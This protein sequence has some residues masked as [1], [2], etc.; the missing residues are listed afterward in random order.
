MDRG[1]RPSK[2]LS[3]R[4][5]SADRA[6]CRA[7]AL[8]RKVA[9]RREA[10]RVAELTPDGLAGDRRVHVRSGSGPLTGRTRS[11]LLTLPATTGIDGVP[12]VAGAPLGLAGRARAGARPGRRR[13]LARST[14]RPG[15][16]QRDATCSWPLTAPWPA[17]GTTCAGCAP[18]CCSAR[19]DQ[20]R[21]RPSRGGH[22]PGARRSDKSAT[23][24]HRRIVGSQRPVRDA[25]SKRP[26]TRRSRLPVAVLRVCPFS[27]R[28][29]TQSARWPTARPRKWR[30]HLKAHR[31]CGD[32]WSLA[33]T[34]P[35]AFNTAP[36][37][38]LAHL[39]SAFSDSV[40]SSR[41]NVSRSTTSD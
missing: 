32:S 19:S 28:P 27:S 7:V 22:W 34:K 15:T 2:A 1:P 3:W 9:R 26:T 29:S 38:L 17:S 41:E 33:T 12:F 11:G 21:K 6:R 10:L 23:R 36:A 25:D 39:T 14:R 18:T 31:R 30:Q 20:P 24:R 5:G 35:V 4:C 40:A 8:P 16:L 37:R 13:R